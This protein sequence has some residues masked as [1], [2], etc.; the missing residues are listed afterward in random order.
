MSA[1]QPE[2]IGELLAMMQQ[3]TVQHTLNLTDDTNGT[4]WEEEALRLR[5]RA[6][7]ALA[8]M[9]AEIIGEDETPPP[10]QCGWAMND[11]CS[12]GHYQRKALR[13]KQR[14]RAIAKGFDM[15]GGE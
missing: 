8:A 6:K 3:A 11:K 13:K 1:K 10:S 5:D 2:T 15:K 7:A 14:Q 4:E 9:I 12:C